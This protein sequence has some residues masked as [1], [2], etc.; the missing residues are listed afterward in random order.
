MEHDEIERLCRG[1]NKEVGDL[2]AALASRC[3]K[4]LDL[5]RTS[6]VL[7]GRV[8]EIERPKSRH[9]SIPFLRVSGRVANFE[10]ANG[11]SGDAACLGQRL[12]D[13]AYGRVAEP[14]QHAGV[15]EVG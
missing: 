3:E 7:G 15:N 10:I 6:D 11:R 8:D 2:A 1:G 13:G 5:Q 14:F 9:E 12:D 4:A